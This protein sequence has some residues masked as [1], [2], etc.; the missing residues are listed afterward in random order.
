MKV[1]FGL[2]Q[3]YLDEAITMQFPHFY[4]ENKVTLLG[5]DNVNTNSH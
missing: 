4:L 5:R 3:W 1:C 2:L